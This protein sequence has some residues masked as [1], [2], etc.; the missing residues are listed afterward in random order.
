MD[1]ISF[2]IISLNCF[3]T[4]SLTALNS[5]LTICLMCS[6]LVAVLSAPL[7]STFPFTAFEL[8]VVAAAV[9]RPARRRLSS[10]LKSD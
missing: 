4:S 3:R 5:T 1:F 6:D 10:S 8:L 7:E 2:L 9:P